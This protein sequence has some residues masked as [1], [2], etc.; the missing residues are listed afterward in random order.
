[1]NCAGQ[2]SMQQEGGATPHVGLVGAVAAEPLDGRPAGWGDSRPVLLASLGRLKSEGA[3]ADNIPYAT[4]ARAAVERHAQRGLVWHLGDALLHVDRSGTVGGEESTLEL[5]FNCTTAAVAAWQEAADAQCISIPAANVHP[6]V[7]IPVHKGAH[8]LLCTLLVVHSLDAE[9]RIKGLGATLL[10][11]AGYSE[12]EYV[13]HGE[14][15]EDLPS[16]LAELEFSDGGGWDS[17]S[18]LHPD[19]RGGQEPS[20]HAQPLHGGWAEGE[21]HQT[22]GHA[23]AREDHCPGDRSSSAGCPEQPIAHSRR[24]HSQG[25]QKAEQIAPARRTCRTQR[26]ADRR[27]A[28][29]LRT[30]HASNTTGNP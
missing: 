15:A 24:C 2:A 18:N 21:Y 3:A 17:M 5:V 14:F 7:S 8:R 26:R 1:M 9:L 11:C 20:A 19:A 28:R 30:I 6:A 10:D 25:W 4:P 29:A 22:C 27:T 13:V 16:D 12:P 23:P